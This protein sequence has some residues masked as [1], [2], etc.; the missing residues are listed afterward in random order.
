M[1]ASLD[2]PGLALELAAYAGTYSNPGYGSMT[3]CAPTSDSS[4]CATVLSTFAALDAQPP[5][6]AAPALYA[7]FPKL[8]TSHVRMTH[9]AGEGF[10]LLFSAVFLHGYGRDASPFETWETGDAEGRVEFVVEDGKV[11]GFALAIDEDAVR[12]RTRAGASN[13]AAAADA[14]FA[15][16]L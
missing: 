14:W 2:G 9:A 11:Q 15:K 3:L 10:D 4:Y 13:I 8:W 16:V 6:P 7:A 5:A 1:S 12:A